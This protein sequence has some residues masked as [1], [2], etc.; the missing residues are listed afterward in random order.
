MVRFFVVIL[1]FVGFI[2][3]FTTAT[4]AMGVSDF[5]AVADGP[6]GGIYNPAGLA[7]LE[8][9]VM[10][11]EH[12]IDERDTAWNSSDDIMV[13]AATGQ[14]ANGALFFDYD[15]DLI[16]DNLYDRF[17]VFGYAFGWNYSK[18]IALGLTAKIGSIGIYDNFSG[19]M[20]KLDSAK[21]FLLDFGMLI[22]PSEGWRLG[23]TVR[24]IGNSDLIDY[25]PTV[26]IAYSGKRWT[27]AGEIA[28]L[29]AASA[30]L[31]DSV[32]RG[33]FRFKLSDNFG[34]QVVK[35]QSDYSAY[36][37]NLI[38]AEFLTK[39]Q[40]SIGLAWCQ[41]SSDFISEKDSL[42]ASIGFQF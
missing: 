42:T 3:G 15:Q 35:E 6:T 12:K 39:N 28:D 22:K 38:G 41:V 34:V 30:A 40:M 29:F 1:I 8:E 14:G 36:E 23:F 32:I 25:E 4:A 9:N 31:E 2:I 11:L 13:Y 10:R 17:S 7:A 20:A 16:I 5:V 33:G 27:V 21:C 18:K 19:A 26:G 24:N 37:S